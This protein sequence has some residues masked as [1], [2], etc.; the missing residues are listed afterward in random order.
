MA[1]ES[2]LSN[3]PWTTRDITIRIHDSRLTIHDSRLT[4][5][6]SRFTIYEYEQSRIY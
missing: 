2:S 1:V 4:I 5:H 6:D 3:S